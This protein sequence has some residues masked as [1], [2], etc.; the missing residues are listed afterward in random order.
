MSDT[1]AHLVERVFP[2]VPTRQW[3]LSLPFKLRY[4]IAYDSELMTAI[5][6]IFVRA[7]FSQLCRRARELLGL[8]RSQCGAVTFVQRFNSALGLNVHF[9]LI[10]L[11]GVYAAGPDAAPEF[12]ELP[13]PEDQEVLEAVT[14][15]ADRVQRMIERRGLEN[16]ADILVENDPGLAALYASGVRGRIAS[17]PNAGNRVATF[18]G[19]RIDGDSLQAMSSP[20]CAAIVGFNLHG[21]VAIGPRDRERLERLLRYAARPPV[22]LERLSR[23][24][25]G[26]L[27]YRLKRMWSDGST[28]VVYEPQDFMARLAALVPAPRVHLTRFHG[29]LAPAAK[30]RSWIVPEPPPPP[31]PPPSVESA[32]SSAPLPIPSPESAPDIHNPIEAKG[33]TKDVPPRRNYAWAYL[34]MRVF[35]LDV[36]RC[37]RCGGRMRILAA[38]HPPDTTRKIL[39]CLGLPSRGPPLAPAIADFTVDIDSF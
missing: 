36:L 34:M 39:D 10:G 19:D 30:W 38:I 3:V 26:R 5:L 33:S 20:R 25:D 6:N 4:R 35:L 22:A 17:G 14:L 29:V 16:E 24:P 13:A 12:H 8:K 37:E 31:L 28:D 11:D 2:W 15:I 7:L 18:G 23:L 9:H 32:G 21:N 1:A 27:V